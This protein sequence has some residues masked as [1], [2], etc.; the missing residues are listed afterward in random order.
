M[1]TGMQRPRV[2][3][4]IGIRTGLGHLFGIVIPG[5]SQE[6]MFLIHHSLIS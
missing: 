5:L 3:T 1:K 6:K 4:E 2:E